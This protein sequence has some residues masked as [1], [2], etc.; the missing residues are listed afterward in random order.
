MK[1][2]S[3]MRYI[4]TRLAGSDKPI[5]N[6][7]LAEAIGVQEI[8]VRRTIKLLRKEFKAPIASSRFGYAWRPAPHEYAHAK[9]LVT[10]FE[11]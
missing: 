5:P 7:T 9:A 1:Q 2:L 4:V 6:D 10:V 11:Q 3:N 8:T